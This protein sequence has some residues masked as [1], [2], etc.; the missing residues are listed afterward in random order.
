MKYA[1]LIAGTET[2]VGKT[3]VVLSL[4]KFFKKQN[5][6]VQTFKCGPD[7]IDPIIHNKMN[8]RPSINLDSVL[9][10]ENHIKYLVNKYSEDADIVIIEGVMG[11]FDGSGKGLMGS[12]SHISQILSIPIILVMDGSRLAKTAGA[13]LY[14]FKYFDPMAEMRA[15]I[16]NHVNS[17]G[18]YKILKESAEEVN[19]KPLG[20]INDLKDIQL[21]ERYL[22]LN[23]DRIS[24]N[25][26]KSF[27]ITLEHVD[28]EDLL[29]VSTNYFYEKTTNIAKTKIQYKIAIAMDNAFQFIYEQNISML[30]EI[31]DIIFFSPLANDSIPDNIDMLY[32]PGGYPENYLE[33]LSKTDFYQSLNSLHNQKKLIVAECGGM[34]LL[35]KSIS[36][37][38]RKFS[39]A[40]L[41]DYE[42][43][44]GNELSISYA[45]IFGKNEFN[46]LKVSAHEFH[47]SSINLNDDQFSDQ[48]TISK[49]GGNELEGIFYKNN[50]FASYFHIYWAEKR[51]FIKR[52]LM[53]YAKEN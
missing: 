42:I 12:S 37:A 30:R 47:L 51:S 10:S 6:T 28:T 50:C 38:E 44:F 14:G 48:F 20:Y 4:L 53:N 11:M 17:L 13:I 31:A 45:E 5:Y 19:V 34:M 46:G 32:L 24:T 1:F 52:L 7:F 3:T 8:H 33:E 39:C 49:N 23:Y 41:F 2:G 36:K 43:V 40:N 15:V 16:F 18:H 35:G 9:M 27:E 25:I 26:E 22:G 21:E 29:E